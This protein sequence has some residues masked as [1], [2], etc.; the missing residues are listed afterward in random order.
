MYRNTSSDSRLR[1]MVVD[2]FAYN[3]PSLEILRGIPN[4]FPQEVLLDMALVL[5]K[6]SCS[7]PDRKIIMCDKAWREHHV[8]EDE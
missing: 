6:H 2:R 4:A 5:A 8:P 7:S 3:L 1:H